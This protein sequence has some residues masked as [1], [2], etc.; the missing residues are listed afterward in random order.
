MIVGTK[1]DVTDKREVTY[2]AA[3][4]FADEEDLLLFEVSAKDDTNIDLALITLVA[5]IKSQ[6]SGNL[7]TSA[8]SVQDS[9][10]LSLLDKRI[11]LVCHQYH[12]YM[13][14]YCISIWAH[15]AL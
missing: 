4:A 15:L 9:L 11:V 8:V 1:I 6:D 12:V 2:E 5:K 10:Q 13:Y 7:E 3:K 14:Y